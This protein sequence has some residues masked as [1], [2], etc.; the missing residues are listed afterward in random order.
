MVPLDHHIRV[1]I[2]LHI[3]HHQEFPGVVEAALEVGNIEEKYND[4]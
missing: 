1:V 4:N 2:V 3:V